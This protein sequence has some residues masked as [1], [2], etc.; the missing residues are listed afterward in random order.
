M[1]ESLEARVAAKVRRLREDRGWTQEQL[2]TA[3]GKK[4]GITVWGLE[5]GRRH[6]NLADLE[7]LAALFEIAPEDFLA[8]QPAGVA[9]VPVDA[10]N[11]LVRVAMWVSRGRSMAFAPD[12]LLGGVYP[13]ATARAGLGLLDEAGLLDA[14]KQSGTSEGK[15]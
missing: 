5:N 6:I 10:L 14:Y 8:E 13:D 4:S 12:P 11:R 1:A 3:L 2:A 15:P 7:A 9:T